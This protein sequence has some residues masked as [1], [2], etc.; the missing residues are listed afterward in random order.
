MARPVTR[1]VCGG[2]GCTGAGLSGWVPPPRRRSGGPWP[3]ICAEL[4][5]FPGVPC[6]ARGGLGR[7]KRRD[8]GE[9][10]M[11][12]AAILSLAEVQR[13]CVRKNGK[14]ALPETRRGQSFRRTAC[15]WR[16][17]HPRA[18][19][20]ARAV[21]EGHENATMRSEYPNHVHFAGPSVSLIYFAPGGGR[22]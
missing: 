17:A 8:A 21:G 6:F 10:A 11:D 7:A 9:T 15:R 14:A 19:A 1:H 16:P 2:G 22:K 4:S 5:A 13:R 3:P 20:G 12:G 18:H